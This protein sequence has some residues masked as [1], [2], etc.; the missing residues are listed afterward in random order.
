MDFE[1]FVDQMRP[2][3]NGLDLTVAIQCIMEHSD[4]GVL[5]LVDEIMKSGGV[6]EDILLIHEKVSQI[7]NCLNILATKFN[8]VLTTLNMQAM[9]IEGSRKIGWI[10]L[11]PPTLEEATSLFGSDA[12]HS[13]ILRRCIVDCNG[14]YHSLETLKVVW[15][16]HP[17]MRCSYTTMI[18]KLGEAMEKKFSQ[19]R[20]TLIRAALGGRLNDSPD[21]PYLQQGIYLN[22]PHSW[23]PIV[24]RISPLQMLLY[25][26]EHFNKSA[27][28]VV[29]T[30]LFFSFFLFFFVVVVQLITNLFCS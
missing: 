15:D 10:K 20:I 13:S 29:Y 28:S 2:L 27:S 11:A 24:P 9:R 18:Q 14:H 26:R 8:V 17:E 30:I 6:V 5:L 21:A 16:E 23:G 1:D 7:G 3:P 4:K 12:A 25:A 19:L 22:T